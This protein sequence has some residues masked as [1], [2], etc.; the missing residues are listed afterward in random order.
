LFNSDDR[1]IVVLT[2]EIPSKPSKTTSTVAASSSSAAGGGSSGDRGTRTSGN[3]NGVV[4]GAAVGGAVVLGILV[5]IIIVVWKWRKAG[6]STEKQTKQVKD[7]MYGTSDNDIQ[8]ERPKE[9]QTVPPSA[10]D[11]HPTYQGLVIANGQRNGAAIYSSPEDEYDNCTVYQSLEKP[12]SGT[13]VYQSLKAG[14]AEPAHT[15]GLPNLKPKPRYTTLPNA[16]GTPIAK[17]NGATAIPNLKGKTAS[18]IPKSK[19]GTKGQPS[20]R[21][22]VTPEP[23]YNVLDGPGSEQGTTPEPLYNVLEGPDRGQ[24]YEA[25]NVDPLYNVLEGPNTTYDS[26]EIVLESNG[27]QNGP[28]SGQSPYNDPLYNVLEGPE[29]D[30]KSLE[31]GPST[32]QEPLYN[33]LKGPGAKKIPLVEQ[34]DPINEPLYNVLEGPDSGGSNQ[35]APNKPR[36]LSGHD[37]LAYEQ[38][39]EMDVPNAAVHRPGTQR[40][41]VYEALRGPTQ[42]VYEALGQ[43]GDPHSTC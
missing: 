15:T 7:P 12:R 4:I 18:G 3:D 29:S 1:T 13:P 9:I 26:A 22:S 14:Q 38:T 8:L 21:S 43:S 28:I 25:R 31:H 36:P 5:I 41:S 11:N 39:L 17:G 35:H 32:G 40:E 33:V 30:Q 42:D 27:A 23:V 10:Q 34:G 16:T 20:Q 37:N 2:A 24:D 6:K 19:P